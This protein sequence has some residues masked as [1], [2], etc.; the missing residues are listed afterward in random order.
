MKK[1]ISFKNIANLSKQ[2]KKINLHI[3]PYKRLKFWINTIT[4]RYLI[5]RRIKQK[6][7]KQTQ[8]IQNPTHLIIWT[9]FVKN[10]EK[11]FPDVSIININMPYLLINNVITVLQKQRLSSLKPKN[12]ILYI[13]HNDIIKSTLYYKNINTF[14]KYKTLI[15]MLQDHFPSSSII[16]CEIWWRNRYFNNKLKYDK[17]NE[18]IKKLAYTTWTKLINRAYT[19]KHFTNKKQAQKVFAEKL[20]KLTI[21]T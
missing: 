20:K 1:K 18:N 9:Y 12:I 7:K 8:N 13:G 2:I 19:S 3:P 4:T 11:Y 14:I 15:F 5:N 16:L 17:F 6:I 21:S 10:I